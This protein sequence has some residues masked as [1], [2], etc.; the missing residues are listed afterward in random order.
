MYQAGAVGY[1]GYSAYADSIS[2]ALKV[3]YAKLETKKGVEKL[4]NDLLVKGSS[5]FW[6]LK[7]VLE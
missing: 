6:D 7:K 1:F 3:L 2:M 5:R 4:I